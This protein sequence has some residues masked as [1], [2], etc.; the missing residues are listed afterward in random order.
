VTL[1]SPHHDGSGLYVRNQPIAPGDEV[2]VRLRVPA[3]S[4]V[5]SVAL[6]YVHDGEPAFVR[7]KVDERNA[8]ETW[9]LARFP[10]LNLSTRYR[11]LISG[12]SQNYAWVNGLGVHQRDVADADDFAI[13]HD[14]GGPDWHLKSVVYEIFP[15]RFATSGLHV[16][17]PAWAIPR[18]WDALPAGR[19]PQTPYE[20]FAGDLR[21]IEQHLGHIEQLGATALYIRP[22]FPAQ[23]THRYDAISFDRVDP[24]L[25]GDHAFSSL[26]RAAHAR[27]L[28]LI[29]D[30]TTNHTGSQHEWF[31]S[32]RGF[33]FFDE[34]LPLGYEAWYGVPSLPKLNWSSG[35]LRKRFEA[36]VRR[37]L[38]GGLDGWRI[39]VANMTGRR[40]DQDL[41]L[42]VA[43][44]IRNATGDALLIAEHAHDF[45][46]D[47]A[48]GSWHGTMNYAGFMRPLWAWLRADKLGED[49]E[50]SFH[51]VPA[52]VPRLDGEDVVSI[53]N[54]FRAGV[55][56]PQVVHSW[57][58]LDSFDSARFKTVTGTRERQ[59][60]GVGLQMTMPGV[61]LICAGDELGLE[62]AWAED[63]RR[64]IPWDAP[65]SWDARTLE[66][67]R[68]LIST[69]RSSDALQHG[70]LRYVHVDSDVIAFL[71]ET[72][73]ERL[74]CLASRRPH[75]PVRVSLA[76]LDADE[77]ET[78]IGAEP[79]TGKD[80]VSLPADGPSFHVWKII[81]G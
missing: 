20:W 61:P 60:V 19:G 26:V 23:S 8:H 55:P 24:L 68:S 66:C 63:A 13:T 15:D 57:S 75:E 43:K 27:G 72:P 42:E 46:A 48:G 49:L 67:Y 40:R 16:A 73:A 18:P 36:I 39:D 70:G 78:V 9:W 30:L 5:E 59:L 62:G 56:W 10:A 44:L 50:R 25:G 17:P 29:G 7:A 38:D 4:G 45:R 77:L 21:G 3:P 53:M 33:Y 1:S 69:R 51:G 54:T 35:E 2:T 81:R 41:N 28:R 22:F 12:G 34:S 52:G 6:R 11:W 65:H 71:R 14:P 80:A 64:T 58:L 79:T 76:H 74:L 47:L 31:P 32:E 37:W